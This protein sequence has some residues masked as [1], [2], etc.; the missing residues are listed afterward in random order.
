MNVFS[1]KLFTNNINSHILWNV[2][3]NNKKQYIVKK[4]Q[5]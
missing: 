5:T 1:K 4:Y 2:K 3:K